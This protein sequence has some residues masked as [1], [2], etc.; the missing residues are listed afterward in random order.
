MEGGLREEVGL[1][2][3]S[4]FGLL[5][6][7]FLFTYS[8]LNGIYAPSKWEIPTQI[9]IIWDNKTSLGFNYSLEYVHMAIRPKYCTK[10]NTEL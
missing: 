9:G 8:K 6:N 2:D 10:I 4:I 7:L 5:S 1:M 3:N